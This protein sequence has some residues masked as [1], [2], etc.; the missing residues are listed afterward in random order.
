MT[1]ATLAHYW[2]VTDMSTPLTMSELIAM[3]TVRECES[4]GI[5]HAIVRTCDEARLELRIMARK[6][7]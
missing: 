7:A 1:R 2:E 3:T 5:P 4:C 6:D